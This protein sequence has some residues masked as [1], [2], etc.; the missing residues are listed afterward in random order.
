MGCPKLLLPWGDGLVID[1][2]LKAWTDSRVARVVIIVRR[3]DHPLRDACGRWPVTILQP[4]DDPPDM[5]AS[6]RYGMQ[7]LSEHESPAA[8][9][10]CFVSPADLPTLS[11]VVIDR[12]LEAYISHPGVTVPRFGTKSGHPPLLP[13]SICA[14]IDRLEADEGMDA[15]IGRCGPRFVDFPATW[16]TPDIDTPEDY[17]LLRKR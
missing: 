11:S 2:V 14:E 4:P 3:D 5:K 12:L 8:G 10:G 15:L 13:W 7:H 1:R 9:D 17:R 16:A 6:L